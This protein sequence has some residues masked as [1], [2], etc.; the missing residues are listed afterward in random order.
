MMKRLYEAMLIEHFQ[1]NDQMALI[2]GPRQCGKTTLAKA[3]CKQHSGSV[4]LNWD[5]PDDRELILRG[6]TSLI[7][8]ASSDRLTDPQGFVALDEI[9][10]LTNWKNYLKGYYD[11]TKTQIKTLMTGSAK[12]DVFKKAGDSL[13]GRYFLYRMHPFSVGELLQRPYEPKEISPPK[14]LSDTKWKTLLEYGG[15]PEPYLKADKR[16]LN[17]WSQ[18]RFQQL[19]EE[20]IQAFTRITELDKME[21]FAKML[22]RHSGGQMNYSHYGKL[23]QVDSK[24]IRNWTNTLKGFYYC[25][26]IQPWHKNISRALIK[27]PKVYLWDW[28]KIEDEGARHETMMALHLLKAVNFWED[29]GLGEYGLY[30]L[31]D[32]DQREVDFLITRNSK[33]WILI[34]VKSS[35]SKKLSPSLQYFQNQ[36]QAEHVFQVAFDLPYEDVDCFSAKK[37]AIVSAKT[38]LSQLV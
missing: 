8:R 22:Q 2:P 4:Y 6:P 7:E 5:F 9:H 31:R 25:F 18:L 3:L 17:R 30:F 35:G 1:E 34:E 36:I 15:F 10:K 29:T 14:K 20:E 11:A 19:F 21:V 26:T 28:S 27:E 24:T 16:F 33:P 23:V 38:F 37:P 32:K 13:M 12:L